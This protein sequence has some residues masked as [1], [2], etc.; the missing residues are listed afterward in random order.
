MP[1][2]ARLWPKDTTT[3]VKIQDMP[4]Y[5][6]FLLYDQLVTNRL[7]RRV[8]A[9]HRSKTAAA[10]RPLGENDPPALARW[11]VI[12]SC[13]DIEKSIFGDQYDDKVVRYS[14]ILIIDDMMT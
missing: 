4:N 13:H 1:H 3:V 5:R 10:K 2:V 14:I 8:D 7:F 9:R 12:M 6:R 11:H